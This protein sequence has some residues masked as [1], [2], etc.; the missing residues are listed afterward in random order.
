M[1]RL[2]WTWIGLAGI[3]VLMLPVLFLL[4][5]L[6][7]M[8]LV[9]GLCRWSQ[10][11]QQVLA[12]EINA[13]NQRH[14]GALVCVQERHGLIVELSMKPEEKSAPAVLGLLAISKATPVCSSAAGKTAPKAEQPLSSG[15]TTW[16]I[17]STLKCS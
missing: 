10:H 16:L 11:H 6:S 8:A 2:N 7:L 12:A 4:W 14:S 9:I 17:N 13:W 15:P 5:P 1:A 3:S